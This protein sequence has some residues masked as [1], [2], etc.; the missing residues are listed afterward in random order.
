MRRVLAVVAGVVLGN[1]IYFALAFALAFV[2]LQPI[3]QATGESPEEWLGVAF[4]GLMPLGLFAGGLLTG[5]IARAIP[6][7]GW[8]FAPLH[9]PGLY[10][11]LVSLPFLLN[12]I[13]SFQVFM[14]V[15][16][17]IWVVSSTAGVLL[18]A[19]WY[20]RR[21]SGHPLDAS[22]RAWPS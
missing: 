10:T 5:Y 6:P 8:R 2:V 13:P 18:G 1:A 4:Y 21:L 22:D 12:T 14:L 11:F 16:G 15:A 7:P 19:R 20:R 17:S 3:Q 9:A